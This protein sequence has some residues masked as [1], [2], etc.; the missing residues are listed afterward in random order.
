MKA[1]I[2]IKELTPGCMPEIIVDGDWID[3]R[4]SRDITLEGMRADTLR[5]H[6]GDKGNYRKV[7][8]KW[9]LVPLGVA[10]K[11]PKGYEA[12]VAPRSSSFKK[13][14]ITVPNSFGVID[15]SYSGNNDEW[16]MPALMFEEG[17][18]HKGERICQF[19]IQ[20]SQ[21]ATVWQKI[22]WLFTNGIKIEQVNELDN[23]DRGG[24]GSTGVK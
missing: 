7:N 17:I 5:R 18:I 8:F 9:E 21:K 13:W 3:L 14:Y 24:F 16:H 15:N 20:L 23:K 6:S 19:R 10:M 2:K 1:K 12:I 11:L 22:K 4:A